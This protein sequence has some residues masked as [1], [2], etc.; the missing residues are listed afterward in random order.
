MEGS[1]YAACEDEGWNTHAFLVSNLCMRA[2]VE[3]SS[4]AAC[5]D[6]DGTQYNSNIHK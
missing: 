2:G 4:S 3:H 6:E 1:T 5:A